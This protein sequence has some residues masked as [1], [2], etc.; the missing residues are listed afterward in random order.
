MRIRSLYFALA[1]PAAMYAHFTFVVPHAGGKSAELIVSETLEPDPVVNPKIADQAKIKVRSA[2]GKDTDLVLKPEKSRFLIDLPGSGN[3]II[4]GKAELG[5]NAGGPSPK[6]YLLIYYPKTVVGPSFGE[7]ATVGGDQVI[8]LVPYGEPGKLMLKL[9]VRG[10]AKPDS[11]MTVVLPGGKQ[12]KVKTNAEGFAGPFSV[13]GRYG[14]WARFWEPGTGERNG[15]SYEQIRHYAT[16]VFDGFAP[17]RALTSLPEA[18]SSFGS[19]AVG[20]FVYV[21]GGHIANTHSYSTAAVSGRFQRWSISDKHWEDLPAGPALQGM[22]LVAHG[23]KIYRVGGMAPQNKP[24]EKSDTHSVAGVARFDPTTKKWED[25]P[26]LPEPRSSHDVSVIGDRLIVAG[27]WNL[28]GKEP[29][30]WAKTALLLDL[31]T[32]PSKAEWKSIPQPIER[33]ALIAAVHNSKMYL[34][35]GIRPSGEVSTD[36]DIYDP[37]TNAWSKGPALPGPSID[38]FAP[39]AADYRGQ[40]FVSMG[41]GSIVRLVEGASP[42]WEDAGHASPRLAHRMVP[43]T[44]SVLILGGALKGKNLDLVEAIS[45]SEGK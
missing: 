41:D 6:P 1:L 24:G 22:N 45:V 28:R 29:A 2:D 15:K 39:A 14:A 30:V 8:E 38:S 40:L 13:A 43:S 37:K 31:S 23:G 44:D 9:L 27:G 26:P 21:Y 5:V 7:K 18:T 11:E 33:R 4:F 16:L 19:V 42:R 3:R 25:L 20:D 34:M 36:V 10:V 17:A 32:G 12:S 35:G